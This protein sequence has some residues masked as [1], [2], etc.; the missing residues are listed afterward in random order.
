[1]SQK[2][3]V[4]N[5]QDLNVFVGSSFDMI[6]NDI[7]QCCSIIDRDKWHKTSIMSSNDVPNL[8]SKF[9]LKGYAISQ[10][11]K[12]EHGNGNAEKP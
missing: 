9:T 8:I 1:M 12:R 5:I 6:T 2:F 3:V 10:G 4:P 7:S 11:E